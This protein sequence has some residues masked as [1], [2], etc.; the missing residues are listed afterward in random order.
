MTDDKSVYLYDVSGTH[1]SETVLS[2]AVTADIP[3]IYGSN[4]EN[5]ATSYISSDISYLCCIND[6]CFIVY[7]SQDNKVKMISAE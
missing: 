7:D 1:Q 3:V 6:G 2:D 4:I 5:S